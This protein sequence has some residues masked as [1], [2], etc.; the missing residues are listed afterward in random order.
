M[1]EIQD[2]HDEMEHSLYDRHD[3]HLVNCR[4][5]GLSDG[6]SLLKKA[7]ISPQEVAILT[8]APLLAR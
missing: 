1:R 8:F 5:E 4:F 7:E 2:Q 3:F 6:K